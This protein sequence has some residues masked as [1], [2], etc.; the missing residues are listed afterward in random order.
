VANLL[1]R[2]LLMSLGIAITCL[3]VIPIGGG[4]GF[5]LKVA[6]GAAGT[7]AV[8]TGVSVFWEV[9]REGGHI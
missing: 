9:R 2:V 8:A 3:G 5:V 7:A 1:E 4:I 6:A